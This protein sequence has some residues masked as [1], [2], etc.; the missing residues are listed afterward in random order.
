MP[1]QIPIGER[2]FEIQIRDISLDKLHEEAEDHATKYKED[3]NSY[4]KLSED[5]YVTAKMLGNEI[6]QLQK[7]GVEDFHI[8]IALSMTLGQCLQQLEYK[9]PSLCFKVKKVVADRIMTELD[10]E[11]MPEFLKRGGK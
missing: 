5:V 10:K 6:T 8:I 1:I 2:L 7:L 3:V 9:S 11:L 4:R